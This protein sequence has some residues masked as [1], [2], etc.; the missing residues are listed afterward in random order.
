MSY[1]PATEPARAHAGIKYEVEQAYCRDVVTIASGSNA[2]GAAMAELTLLG[3]I[4][5][6][7]K[8]APHDPAATDGTEVVAGIL[9]SPDIDAGSADADAAVLVRGPACVVFD[10]LV[11]VNALDA[12][13]IAAAKAD[14]LALGIKSVE[15]I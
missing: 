5:A 15:E 3:K 13:A 2:T 1:T 8:Y 6:S 7:D 10:N 11:A 4:T 12:A 14:L 9:I